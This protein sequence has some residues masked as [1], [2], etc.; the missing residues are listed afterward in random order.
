MYHSPTNDILI[1]AVDAGV[2][3]Q[4][5]PVSNSTKERTDLVIKL[6][7]YLVPRFIQAMPG[8][9]GCSVQ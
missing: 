4:P 2:R 9:K 6:S 1:F 5:P 7:S 3:H 8:Y